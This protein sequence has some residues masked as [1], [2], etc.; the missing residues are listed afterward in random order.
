VHRILP[1]GTLEEKVALLAEVPG[2][3]VTWTPALHQCLAPG[4]YAWYLVARGEKGV[5]RL[6][7]ARYF[8]ISD[9]PSPEA[10]QRALEVLESYLGRAG[11]QATGGESPEVT[12]P[13]AAQKTSHEVAS[14]FV[15][16][17]SIF[18]EGNPV[19]TAA[20]DGEGSGLDADLLDGQHL[21][22]VTTSIL[23]SGAVLFFDLTV[24]PNGWTE[25]ATAQG[26]SIVG[27]PTGGTLGGTVG[28]AL[29][30]L[31]S[32]AHSHVIDPPSS[33]SSSTGTHTHLVDPPNS[34]STSAGSHSH[35]I[36]P[37]TTGSSYDSHNHKW[38]QYNSG[39]WVA[40]NSSGTA[41]LLTSWDNGMG[42]EGSGWDPLAV[43]TNHAYADFYT[44]SDTHNHTTDIGAF[45][46]GSVVNHSHSVNISAFSAGASGDHTHSTNIAP[47]GAASTEA[48][49]PYIQY[50]VCRKD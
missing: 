15:T 2:N 19:F 41:E 7:E 21:S 18:D 30:N 16:T 26:R 1:G 27:R 12:V 4:R 9:V 39:G 24:C 47:F 37:P 28:T 17:A 10:V 3:A 20:N 46:S 25:I 36:N 42:N 49:H 40:Y 32:R 50:L 11:E 23:P 48:G 43:T 5:D 45:T 6:S 35:S 13:V 33:S 8:S 29:S 14:S 34:G 31:E 38:S 22:D 44:L